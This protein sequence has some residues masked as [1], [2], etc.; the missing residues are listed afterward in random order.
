LEP[1]ENPFFGLKREIK[2]ESSLEIEIIKPLIVKHFI[3][4]DGQTITM[5]IFFASRRSYNVILSD[6]HSDYN[7]LD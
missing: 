2:E 5:I 4:E 6:E 3:R 1:G 7:W